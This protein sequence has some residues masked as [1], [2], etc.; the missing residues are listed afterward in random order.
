VSLRELHLLHACEPAQGLPSA[1]AAAEAAGQAFVLET[2]QRTVVLCTDA[3][4]CDHLADSFPVEA[5]LVRHVGV[6]AY[7]ALLRLACGLESRLAGETE[8]FGQIKKAWAGFSGRGSLLAAQLSGTVQGLFRDVKAIRSQCLSGIGS[9]SYGSLVRRVLDSA[10]LKSS[11]S[12]SAG[13]VLIVGAGQLAASV[14]PWLQAN[15]I[16]LWNRSADKAEALAAEMRRRAPGK[17]VRVLAADTAAELEAWRLATHVVVC[18]PADADRDAARVAAWG[19]PRA[20]RGK[21]V[22]LGVNLQVRAPAGQ[23]VWAA[24]AE[25]LHMGAMYDLLRASNELR[26]GLLD[27]ARQACGEKAQAAGGVLRIE[28]PTHGSASAIAADSLYS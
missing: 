10:L 11:D 6:A 2:C 17:L 27:R 13:A 19:Q 5:Q 22:H 26:A 9:A 28:A 18:V 16:W 25:L 15:E 12:G 7:E 14:A 21:L 20:V 3:E 8:V 1:V 23:N 24:A 4:L